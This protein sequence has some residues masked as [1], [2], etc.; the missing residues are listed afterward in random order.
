[1]QT[2]IVL[3]LPLNSASFYL[4]VF[5]ATLVQYNLHYMAKTVA[6]DGS[7]RLAWSQRNRQIHM[8]FIALGTVIILPGLFAFD[9]AHYFILAVLGAIT[10][11]YSFPVFRFAGIKRLKDYGIVKIMVLSLTWTIVTVWLPVGGMDY[12]ALIFFLMLAKRFVF[13]FILCM[14]FDIRDQQTDEAEGIRT[15]PVIL[16]RRAAYR[17]TFGCLLLFVAMVSVETAFNT[18]VFWMAFM[19]SAA[20]TALVIAYARRETSDLV[21][22]LAVDGMMLLQPLLI[23]T[24][25]ELN[26]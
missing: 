15:I 7:P 20:A 22:L 18:Q 14:V 26:L 2:N 8:G 17:L 21:C 1:M 25:N 4:F 23:M 3:G 6:A 11:L 24:F 5:G 12:D 10:L 16:G 19:I 9:K 13:V